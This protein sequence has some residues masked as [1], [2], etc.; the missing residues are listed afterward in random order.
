MKISPVVVDPRFPNEAADT[1]GTVL[2]S[3]AMSKRL[4]DKRGEGR[5]GW[6]QP[7]VCSMVELKLLLGGAITEAMKNQ[8]EG[9]DTDLV[10]IANFCMMIWN[11]R[12]YEKEN[13]L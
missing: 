10:D 3:M 8:G 12:L 5:H 6:H 7:E 11:R 9:V 2:F 13:T 4:E 1:V